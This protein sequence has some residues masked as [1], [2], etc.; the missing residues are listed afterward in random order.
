MKAKMPRQPPIRRRDCGSRIRAWRTEGNRNSH[1]TPS[2]PWVERLRAWQSGCVWAAD[3]QQQQQ[4]RAEAAGVWRCRIWSRFLPRLTF[5]R[6][7][8]SPCACQGL[9]DEIYTASATSLL[10][11]KMCAPA[12]PIKKLGY[13]TQRTDCSSTVASLGHKVCFVAEFW[14]ATLLENKIKTTSAR[15]LSLLSLQSFMNQDSSL[16]PPTKSPE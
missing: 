14:I 8:G 4:P 1:R 15:I 2:R 12:H 3:Q 13:S 10:H 16:T 11:V 6:H 7:N 9:R 5:R